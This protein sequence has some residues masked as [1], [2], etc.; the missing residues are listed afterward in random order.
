[1]K[2][3]DPVLYASLA[4]IFI[5]S[6]AGAYSLSR[7]DGD[8]TLVV[9]RDGSEIVRSPLTRFPSRKNLEFRHDG[10]FNIISAGT[11][12]V[13]MISADCPGGDCLRT[14]TIDSPGET[15]VCMPHKLTV[16]LT[17]RRDGAYDAMSY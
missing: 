3:Y 4:F 5:L 13:R 9:T 7:Q 17:S 12:G 6:C 11:D 15:I 2:K 8:L 1:M 16:K 10:G 14:R